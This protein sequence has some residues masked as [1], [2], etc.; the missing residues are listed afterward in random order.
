MARQALSDMNVLHTV[1]FDEIAWESVHSALHTVPRLFQV[2]AC[3]Q[4]LDIASTNQIV[5]KWDRAVNPLCPSCM[6]VRETSEHVLMCSEAG[7]VN[8]LVQTVKLLDGWLRKMD[9][10]L[11]LQEVIVLYCNG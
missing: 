1:Q 5:S 9:T 10:H 7:Q 2:W 4:V 8:I 6:Q 3:K 11:Q